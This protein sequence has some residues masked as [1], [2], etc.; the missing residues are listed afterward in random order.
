M[1]VLLLKYILLNAVNVL[2]LNYILFNADQ[3]QQQQTVVV[4]YVL[5]ALFVTH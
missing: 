3:K 4:Q 2:L 5:V 1:S